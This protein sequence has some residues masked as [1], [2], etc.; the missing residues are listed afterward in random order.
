MLRSAALLASSGVHH[1]MGSLDFKAAYYDPT[2]DPAYPNGNTRKRLYIFWHEY[3]PFMLYLRKRCN[4]TMLLSRHQ[5]ADVLGEV[6]DIFGFGTVRGSSNRGSSEAVRE[7]IQKS[8]A[9]HLTMT[10]DGPRGPRRKLSRGCVFLASKLQIP[11]VI[12]GLG[13]ERPRRLRT[14][15]RFA[16]PKPFSRARCIASPE[17]FIPPDID[18]EMSV[19]YAL[20]IEKMM[21]QLCDMAEDWA[22]SGDLYLGESMVQLGPLNDLSYVARP[23]QAVIVET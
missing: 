12:L 11:I 20:A 17:I 7:M 1:W 15:D 8:K 3:I 19:Q 9:G 22:G 10:P 23:C 14:W 13:Y 21:S 5:D 16:I 2:V 4:L 6:A 18:K